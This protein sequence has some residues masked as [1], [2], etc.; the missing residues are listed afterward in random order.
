MILCAITRMSHH[1]SSSFRQGTD[2]SP[3]R[4]D[5][6]V[7]APAGPSPFPARRSPGGVSA[8]KLKVDEQRLLWFHI[9]PRRAWA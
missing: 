5:G 9:L 1:H 8:P 4:D 7:A 6:L 3:S 2:T